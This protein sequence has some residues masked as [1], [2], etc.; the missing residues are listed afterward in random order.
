[1]AAGMVDVSFTLSRH[2]KAMLAERGIELAWVEEVI[3]SPEGSDPKMA[4]STSL[5][6]LQATGA[7]S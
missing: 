6:A 2:A 5:S 4:R 1:M 3:K 7:A